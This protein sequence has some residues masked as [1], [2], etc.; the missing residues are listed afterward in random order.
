VAYDGKKKA[1]SPKKAPHKDSVFMCQEEDEEE[2]EE[3]S[4]DPSFRV[5][6]EVS[7]VKK[8]FLC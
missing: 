3:D 4:S 1:K 6:S 8:V 5:E 7:E 2:E